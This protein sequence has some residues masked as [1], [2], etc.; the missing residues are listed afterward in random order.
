M[1]SGQFIDTDDLITQFGAT[2]IQRWADLD[3][4]GD[5]GTIDASIQ[6][7]IDQGEED[8]EDMFRDGRYRVPF[9]V[10]TTKMKVW[11]AKLAAIHLY[12]NRGQDDQIDDDEQESGLMTSLE[13]KIQKEIDLYSAASKRLNIPLAA[14]TNRT[15][16]PQ[17]IVRR[18]GGSG[19]F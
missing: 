13:G 12:Q 16:A 2:N 5:A 18:P 8:L 14:Q 7:A 15:T 17:V 19:C 9:T 4:E 11:M 6:S 1:A 10:A 3:N